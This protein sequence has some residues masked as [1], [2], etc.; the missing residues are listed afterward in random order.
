LELETAKQAP[1]S[2]L[3]FSLSV[4]VPAALPLLLSLSL[5][6]LLLLLKA[7]AAKGA[8]FVL[9]LGLGWGCLDRDPELIAWGR[10]APFLPPSHGGAHSPCVRGS[11]TLLVLLLS[12]LAQVEGCPE[13]GVCESLSRWEGA[14]S[15]LFLQTDGA[16]GSKRVWQN[17]P[18]NGPWGRGWG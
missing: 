4:L 8:V 14:M 15:R 1:P 5:F 7:K 12:V 10:S 2:C 11:F 17:Y 13:A 16:D 6:L 9:G 18:E 3:F